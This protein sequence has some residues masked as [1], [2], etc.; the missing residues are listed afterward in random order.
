MLCEIGSTFWNYSLDLPE[1]KEKFWWENADYNHCFLKSGRNAM[2]ALARILAKKKRILLP[3][4]T[5][6]TVIQPFVDENWEIDYYNVHKNLRINIDSLL[7]KV[8][9]FFPTVVL[10]HSYFGFD[11]IGADET[12]IE[13]LQKR[14][15]IIIEDITQS[16][17]SNHHLKC[18]DYYVSSL[19]KFLAI[20]DGGVVFSKKKFLLEDI[21]PSDKKIVALAKT[22]FDQ[23]RDY[24][25]EGN[26]LALK[27]LFRCNYNKLN[28]M[29]SMNSNVQMISPESKIIFDSCDLHEIRKK[30]VTN[31]IRLMKGIQDIKYIRPVLSFLPQEEAPLYLP[32]YVEGNRLN[33]Q[34]HLAENGIYCPVIWPKP[35]QIESE[36]SEVRF[37]YEHMLC[38]PVDQRYG[39]EEMNRILSMLEY[40]KKG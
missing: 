32:I 24:M 1:R 22:A 35:S 34:A 8:N 7:Q 9:D 3:V 37:M 17:F 20:P 10:F 29:I 39:D 36:D 12:V 28:E 21:L 6:E 4:Y 18:A 5:C 23:K 14:G 30:R 26:N 40:E 15:I 13:Q 31:Y 25:M 11:T 27:D 38:I 2:K 16:L 19:R 33:L